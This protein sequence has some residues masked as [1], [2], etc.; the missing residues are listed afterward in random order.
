MRPQHDQIRQQIEAAITRVIDSSWYILGREV[1][2]FENQFADYCNVKHCIGV[3]N[4]LDA[5]HMILRGYDIG[6]GDEVIV[7]ANT[8]IATV[9]AINY[10]GATPVFVE[11]DERTYNINPALIEK[12][13]TPKTKAILCVHLYGQPADMEPIVAIAAKYNLKVIED[14]AQAHGAMYKMEKVGNLG[15]AAGFSFYPSKNLGAL[16]DGGCVTTNDATLAERIKSLRNYG[17]VK[18]AYNAYKGFNTRLDEIQ[19]AVLRVKLDYLDMWNLERRKIAMFYLEGLKNTNLTLPFVP[20]FTEPV[21]H[22]FVIRS[23]NRDKI[24]LKLNSANIGTLIHYPLPPH[25]QE[26]Y[27]DM[28]LTKGSFPITENIANQILSLP[29]WVGLAEDELR[30]IVDII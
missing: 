27:K 14:A 11:P 28:N 22:L 24:Q 18:K 5:L 2:M 29:I 17:S 7:P 3:G 12:A 21:W 30:Q 26:A 10:S 4:G 1:E 20:D 19:A 16:G 15:D 8:Y 25:L 9:L 23:L 6:S 13:I